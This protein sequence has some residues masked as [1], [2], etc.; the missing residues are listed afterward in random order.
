MGQSREDD[1]V[2]Y[3]PQQVE[4]ANALAQSILERQ[5][6]IPTSPEETDSAKEESRPEKTTVSPSEA[7]KA[8]LNGAV[9][10]LSKTVLEWNYYD[11][12]KMVFARRVAGK[13]INRFCGNERL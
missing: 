12:E 1:A 10:E 3:S 6:A 13:F 9:E 2:I 8:N 11:V 7:P 5:D 4:V